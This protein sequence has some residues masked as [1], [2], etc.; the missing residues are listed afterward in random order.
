MKDGLERRACALEFQRRKKKTNGGEQRSEVTRGQTLILLCFHWGKKN[1]PERPEYDM[2]RDFWTDGRSEWKGN[3]LIYLVKKHYK[4]GHCDKDY[5]WLCCSYV[6]RNNCVDSG[7]DV[8]R[9]ELF[10]WTRRRRRP[11]CGEARAVTVAQ[12]VTAVKLVT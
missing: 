2:I 4:I 3:E 9:N 8:P 6:M 5:G 7:T 10:F 1:E 12:S 11:A